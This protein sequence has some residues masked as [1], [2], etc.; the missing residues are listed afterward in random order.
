MENIFLK[1]MSARVQDDEPKKV[2]GPV[3]TLSREYGCY[4]SKIAEL[5]TAKINK[6]LVE[7]SKTQQWQCL[8]KEILDEAAKALDTDPV[9]IAH[10]FGADKN[11][12]F[13][14]L[15][16]SFSAKKYA[17]DDS[18]KKVVQTVVKSY[19]EQGNVVIVG[20][21]GCVIAHHI[22]KALHIKLIAP[23]DWRIT[24]IQERYNIS[25]IQARKQVLE[26]D[27][28]RN[29]F[30]KFYRGN[31]PEGDLFDAVINRA[32]FSEEQIIEMIFMMA[33]MKNL[34]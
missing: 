22:P 9:K 26:I 11:T 27:E 7:H 10:I 4:A 8:S 1:Y 3:I 6:D 25:K 23:L 31:K 13:G 14:D 15:A 32:V 18:I 33:K 21:A 19:A 17:S 12:F 24:R 30:M 29:T 34:F 16:V 5:V 20:R 28:K 2:P